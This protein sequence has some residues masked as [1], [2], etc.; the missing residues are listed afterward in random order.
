MVIKAHE[1]KTEIGGW[2]QSPWTEF[3]VPKSWLQQGIPYNQFVQALKR[4]KHYLKSLKGRMR[5]SKSLYDNL[6]SKTHRGKRLRT[7]AVETASTVTGSPLRPATHPDHEDPMHASA[8]FPAELNSKVGHV[9]YVK[10]GTDEGNNRLLRRPPIAVT[11]D[12]EIVGRIDVG[13]VPS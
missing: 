7:S 4:P 13:S 8:K 12:K 11:A 2:A 6:I 5:F 3:S 10:S 9:K 1:L